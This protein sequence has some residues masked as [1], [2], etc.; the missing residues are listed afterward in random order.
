MK[1]GTSY[2]PLNLRQ[3]GEIFDILGRLLYTSPN[4]SKRGELAP[5]LL[6]R[7]GGEVLPAGIYIIRM[8]TNKGLIIKKM[9]NIK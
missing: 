1:K 5:S 6:E 3:E 2:A 7:A 9:T 4:P 8:Q